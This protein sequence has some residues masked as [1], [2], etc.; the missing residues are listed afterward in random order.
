M[1]LVAALIGFSSLVLLLS[2]GCTSPRLAVLPNE[3]QVIRDQL[4]L[5]S[6]FELPQHHRL[7]EDLVVR[8]AEIGNLL[9]VSVGESPIHI[10]LFDTEQEFRS[11]ISQAHPDF[12][13]RRALFVKRDD[14]LK[15]YSVWNP[16]VAEDLRHEVTHGYLHSAV[17]GLPLWLDEGIAEFF[18]V[19]RGKRGFNA[20]HAYLLENEWKAGRWKPDLLRLEKLSDAAAMTQL[21]YAESWLWTHFLL[22]HEYAHHKPIIQ[23][24]LL[25]LRKNGEAF[26]ISAAVERE[27][28]NAD[29]LLI[30][31]LRGLSDQQ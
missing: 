27:F 4:V 17:T 26:P 23:A 21:E 22:G 15:I 2:S 12:P 24:H 28:E 10:Y 5:H 19:E 31:H 3:H 11:Y 25:Q 8:R 30:E 9:G 20:S 14:Q 18:E 16:R 7:I 6:D 29:Q 13:D 1:P